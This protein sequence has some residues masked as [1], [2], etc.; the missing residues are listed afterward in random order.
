VAEGFGGISRFHDIL[1]A[2]SQSCNCSPSYKRTALA[3][4]GQSAI[5]RHRPA[6]SYEGAGMAPSQ[7]GCDGGARQNLQATA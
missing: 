3:A 1:R 5:M 2:I 6:Q 4:G 7:V